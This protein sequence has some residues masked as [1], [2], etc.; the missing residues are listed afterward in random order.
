M[1]QLALAILFLALGGTAGAQPLPADTVI[2]DHY[3]IRFTPDLRN[4]TFEGD[5]TIYVQVL[6][7]LTTKLVLHAVDLTFDEVTIQD[8]GRNQ[9]ATVTPTAANE[10][11]TLAVRASIAPGTVHIH[12]RFH[13][14]LNDELRGL[15]L[16]Q[17]NGR[18]YAVSQF[19]ATDARRAFPCFDQPDMKA[20]FSISAVVDRGDT[21]ISNGAVLSDTPGPGDDKHTLSFSITPKMS[22]YLVALTVGDFK[23]LEGK[24]EDV[25]IR[26]CATPDKT[27]MGRFALSAAENIL[28][29]YTRYFAIR[30]PF[31]KLD[32]VAVPDFSAG[33]MENSGAIFF[34]ESLLL[35]DPGDDSM[36]NQKPV[37]MTIAHEMAHQWFG[38][39]VT[40][41]WWDDIWLNEGFATWMAPKPL[42]VWKPAWH[43][44]LDAATETIEAMEVDALEATRPI[45]TKLAT[46]DEINEAFDAVA[47]QKAASVLR[48]VEA[49]VGDRVF[50]TGVNAYLKKFAYGNATT[51][52]F[53]TTL[54]DV[55]M[56]PVDQVMATF[57]DQPGV[58]L[59][60][61]HA[62]C[63][64]SRETIGVTGERFFAAP[65]HPVDTRT[66]WTIPLRIKA[67]SS[68][69]GNKPRLE[70][71]LFTDKDRAFQVPGCRDW[72]FANGDAIGYYRTTYAPETIALLSGAAEAS[73][74]AV[75]RLAFLSDEWALA[76]SGRHN[77]G[78]YLALVAVLKDDTTPQVLNL[79]DEGLREIHDR[80]ATG[81][82]R[83]KFEAWVRGQFGP[84]LT[85]ADNG[86]SASRDAAAVEDRDSRR[87][88]LVDICGYAGRDPATLARAKAFALGMG[89]RRASDAPLADV[90]F[91]L[92]ALDG[93]EAMYDRLLAS[94]RQAR[95]P[96]DRLRGLLALTAF[97]QPA[98]LDRTLS[99]VIS[100][101]VRMQDRGDLVAEVLKN[102]AGRQVA[103]S[104]LKGHWPEL[105]KAAIGDGGT[106]LVSAASS[107][108]DAASRDDVRQFFA[109]RAPAATRT[110]AQ[111][112]ERIGNCV[113]FVSR[114]Q[115]NLRRWLSQA[116]TTRH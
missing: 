39:L 43:V 60:A 36:G 85:R 108:C 2:P 92:A 48:M 19:E 105:Q 40:M 25:P 111:T 27:G 16:S 100:D 91:P 95:A 94:A 72:A 11:V 52:G 13:G 68:D 20:S 80:L 109:G 32:L 65:G 61:V 76:R 114:Q 26:V 37:A 4:A 93:D 57:V 88:A 5:E 115:P 28:T 15:Y 83:E 69:P 112:V 101:Q 50:Q 1:R 22:T 44:E 46:P 113:E 33:A 99:Y 71:L 106:G 63:L 96:Q 90:L 12:I 62:G 47:Y 49:W 21:A 86:A 51:E 34:R 14:R 3:Q 53:W 41:K 98:L 67:G 7:A 45:R 58:P 8:Q 78:T 6:K 30:Y 29:Y 38:D 35:L 75:E 64:E 77:I 110:L 84:E 73:L 24:A 17:A 87:A 116:E 70:P 102:P 81:D 23:C 55:A 31:R 74:S 56:R 97:S 59:L 104:F 42:A 18:R 66:A 103:W 9:V 89:D 82:D 79:V 107:F 54:A 10:T